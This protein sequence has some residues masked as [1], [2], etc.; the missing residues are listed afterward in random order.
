[1]SAQAGNVIYLG[2][3]DWTREQAIIE[4]QRLGFGEPLWLGRR[5][6]GLG[7]VAQNCNTIP[8]KV[9]ARA[10]WQSG[11]GIFLPGLVASGL[12]AQQ[13]HIATAQR[14]MERILEGEGGA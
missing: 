2:P 7:W 9:D 12:V 8:A 4:S 10:L 13:A 3:P 1:M 14:L 11:N 6:Y 5:G